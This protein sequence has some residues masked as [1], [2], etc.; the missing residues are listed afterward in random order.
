[1]PVFK[2]GNTGGVMK[3][4]PA[5]GKIYNCIDKQAIQD[6]LNSD[7]E[8]PYGS[9]YKR[10]EEEFAKYIGVK[11]AYFVNSGSSA[12]LV[13]F[14]AA[15]EHFGLHDGD[16]IITVAACFPT[17]V[18][19]IIQHRCVPVFID[20]DLDTLNIK[21][22]LLEEAYSPKV[23]GVF[24][25][26]SIGNPFNIDEVLSFCEKHNLFLIEDCADALTSKY[27]GEYVGTFGHIATTSFYP[28]HCM[29]TGGGGMVYTNDDEIGFL[30]HSYRNWGRHSCTCE[31]NEDNLCGHRFSGN[32][33]I[34]PLGYDHKMVFGRL[35]YNLMATNPQA[36]L[37]LAQLQRL[38]F[39]T[40]QRIKNFNYLKMRILSSNLRGK[41]KLMKLEPDASPFCFPILFKTMSERNKANEYL[42]SHGVETRYFFSGNIIRQPLFTNNNYPY[43]IVGDLKNTDEVMC[44]MLFVGCYHGLNVIDMEVIFNVLEEYFKEGKNDA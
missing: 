16:E 42:N 8:I 20:I 7:E 44:N 33:G 40:T 9:Y 11:H 24:L 3:R 19:P 22:E 31:A 21:T 36:A 35:G 32:Y 43:R 14:S 27:N 41:V 23:K 34:L 26:H 4:I 15:Y 18:T 25:A 28:A 38:D 37:G 1:M 29:T 2:A 30:I 13:A 39:F 6:W 10:F 5:T 17:T 12:N